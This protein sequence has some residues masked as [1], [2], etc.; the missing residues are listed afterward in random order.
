MKSTIFWDITPCSPLKV[1][2]ISPPSSGSKNKPSK[3]LARKQ[4]ASSVIC[5]SETS[6]HFQ[7]TT[8]LYIPEDSTLHNHRCEDLKSYIFN[9]LIAFGET[10]MFVPVFTKA[11]HRPLSWD[12]RIRS[13]I[14][15]SSS[16]RLIWILWRARCRPDGS[17]ES[18]KEERY[19]ATD[20]HATI[21]EP[22][23]L[24]GLFGGRVFFVVCS[25]EVFSLW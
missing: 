24:C 25:V 4:V 23:F 12:R 6:V 13:T 15:C 5:S 20:T 9:K 14:Y 7:R 1:R 8:R 22:S 10:E 2:S 16:V 17:T 3:K 21:E 19:M 11:N 18:T